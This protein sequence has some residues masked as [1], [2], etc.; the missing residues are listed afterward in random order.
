MD[1]NELVELVT[2]YL[3]GSLPA[4][5]RSAVVE[6]LDEC[7]GCERYVEQFRLTIALLGEMPDETLAAPARQRLLAE[8]TELSRR[9]DPGTP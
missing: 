9:T 6:H 3:D 8:F 4:D 1:C 2:A 7:P 5:R